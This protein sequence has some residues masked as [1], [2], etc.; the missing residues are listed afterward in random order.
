M[1]MKVHN[2]VQRYFFWAIDPPAM[3]E[4]SKES[5]E[6]VLSVYKRAFQLYA[7]RDEPGQ[8]RYT[9]PEV[10]VN[11]MDHISIYIKREPPYIGFPP[12]LEVHS[13]V[14]WMNIPL[15]F[16]VIVGVGGRIFIDLFKNWPL[17]EN[18]TVSILSG[19]RAQLERG[20]SSLPDKLKHK[21]VDWLLQGTGVYVPR[22]LPQ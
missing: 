3:L 11:P 9:D 1:N 19:S 14:A 4:V 21:E 15:G 5:R 18:D 10:V 7:P 16:K 20:R 12:D 22:P 13:I 17:N 8:V 6:V 2:A